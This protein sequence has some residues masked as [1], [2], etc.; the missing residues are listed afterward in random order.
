MG[1]FKRRWEKELDSL[2][3]SLDREFLPEEKSNISIE[4]KT[5]FYKRKK[6]ISVGALSFALTLILT[7]VLTFSL[8]QPKRHES[9]F[10]VEINPAVVFVLNEDGE[11]SSLTAINSDADVIVS[12]KETEEKVIGKNADDA[13]KNY[14]D[15]VMQYGFINQENGA[16]VRISTDDKDLKVD[17]LC[18]TVKDFLCEKGIMNVVFGK[19]LSTDDFCDLIG[20]VRSEEG[21]TVEKINSLPTL[22]AE[23]V[24]Q[25]E[26]VEVLKEEYFQTVIKSVVAEYV[27]ALIDRDPILQGI[28]ENVSFSDI[29]KENY[30]DTFNSIF[31]F[32]DAIINLDWLSP[33]LE[34][35]ESADDYVQMSKNS[36]AFR[37]SY[38][39][40]KNQAEYDKQKTPISK[41]S[42]DEYLQSIIAEYGSLDNYW[43]IQ[44]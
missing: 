37:Q 31:A 25:K 21:S 4:K 41:E 12:L 8:V 34:L 16:T 26:D 5:P 35:P 42:A 23:K 15:I 19:N 14:V 29:D 10:V 32:M 38:L 39:K 44:K 33:M 27:L 11:V 17:G 24:A 6:F 20:V 22:Y 7:F 43:N 18:D 2:T 30:I 40:D 28:L 13:L 1:K 9:A 3:Y 36:M